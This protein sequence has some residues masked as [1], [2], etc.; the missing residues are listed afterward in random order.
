MLVSELQLHCVN[1]VWSA[2][3]LCSVRIVPLKKVSLALQEGIHSDSEAAMS[4]TIDLLE[5]KSFAG[6]LLDRFLDTGFS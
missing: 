2:L 4:Q 1:S 6:H 3:D 5:S